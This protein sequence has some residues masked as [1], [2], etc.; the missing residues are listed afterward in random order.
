MSTKIE[1]EAEVK[2]FHALVLRVEFAWGGACLWCGLHGRHNWDCPVFTS[3]GVV[4]F[5]EL[6]AVPLNPDDPERDRH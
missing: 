1:L 6:P 5:G 4:R 3:V 2:R